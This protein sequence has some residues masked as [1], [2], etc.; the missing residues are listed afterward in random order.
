[1]FR[2]LPSSDQYKTMYG[3]VFDGQDID[4]Y[5]TPQQDEHTKNYIL[6]SSST[7]K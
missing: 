5:V 3:A 4:R 7:S 2:L 6:P 1:M